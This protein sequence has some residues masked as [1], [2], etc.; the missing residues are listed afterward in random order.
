MVREFSYRKKQQDSLADF[1]RHNGFQKVDVPR[2]YVPLTLRGRIAFKL[3]LHHEIADSIPEPVAATFRKIAVT[4]IR[5]NFLGL[6][7][8]SGIVRLNALQDS[9]RDIWISLKSD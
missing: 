3:G 6:K 5:E 9:R 2:Y 8:P 1:K 4:G 7:T